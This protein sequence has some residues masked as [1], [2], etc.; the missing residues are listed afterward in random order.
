ML[1]R[2]IY[3]TEERWF[4][5]KEEVSCQT[6]NRKKLGSMI[7]PSAKRTPKKMLFLDSN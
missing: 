1:W 5:F 2:I 3:R 4:N 7:K 6:I